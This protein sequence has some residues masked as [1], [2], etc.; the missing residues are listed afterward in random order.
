MYGCFFSMIL[1]KV[2]TCMVKTVVVHNYA[3][4]SQ[5]QIVNKLYVNS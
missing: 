2:T 3:F 4:K 1:N 5:I